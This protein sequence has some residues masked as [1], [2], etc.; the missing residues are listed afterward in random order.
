MPN[1]DRTGRGSRLASMV[2][3]SS[4]LIGELL[5]VNL[6]KTVV[7]QGNAPHDRPGF[8]VGHLIGNR[9]SFLCSKAPMLRVPETN[10]LHRRASCSGDLPPSPP[11]EQATAR[12]DQAWKS[13][14]GD[15]AG[16]GRHAVAVV[17]SGGRNII[18]EAAV[19]GLCQRTLRRPTPGKLREPAPPAECRMRC[20]RTSQGSSKEQDRRSRPQ[21]R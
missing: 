5:L 7:V 3:R 11:A 20:L 8:L 2:N 16:N 10:F 21:H 19:G 1:A 18:C 4:F 6:S 15:G 13:S 14:T 9:A 17:G 12:Q